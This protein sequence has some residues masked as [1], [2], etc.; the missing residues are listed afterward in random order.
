MDFHNIFIV[1]VLYKTD[2][3]KSKT[4]E[5]LSQ[6]LGTDVGLMVY[7]NSP[8][9]QYAGDSFKFKNFNVRYY[10]DADNKGLTPAYNLALHLATKYG[11][12]WLLLLDQDTYFSREY[13]D[14]VESINSIQFEADVVAIVPNVISIHDGKP[15]S[16]SKMYCGGL[17][18][19]LKRSSGIISSRISGINSG[20]ILN[21]A[22]LNSV[23]G[24]SRDYSLDMVDHWYF[25][26]IY[27]SLKK[28]YVLDA[29][30]MQDLSVLRDFEINLSVERYRQLLKAESRFVSD[31]GFLGWLVFRIRLVVRVFKQGTFKSLDYIKLTLSSLF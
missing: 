10:H 12:H 20:S 19:P 21:V 18:R 4:I 30:V 11:N 3:S 28:V 17:S 5:S 27:R 2:L 15:I 13:C 7:D 25:R 9:R 24:F 31:E 1:I 26:Q 6:C 8:H 23:G 16:P 14:A 29:L 22:Y